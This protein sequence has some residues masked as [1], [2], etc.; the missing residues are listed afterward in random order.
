MRRLFFLIII[1]ILFVPQIALAAVFGFSP[2]SGAYQ[3]NKSATVAVVIN[4]EG[5]SINAFSGKVSV[6]KSVAKI[7]SINDARSVSTFW[8]NRPVADNDGNITFRG[9]I[10]GGFKGSSGV[11]FE[12]NLEILSQG[13][14]S[15]TD[16]E[17]LL[18]D[19]FGTPANTSSNKFSVEI[20]AQ[21]DKAE[22]QVD[23]Q[24][25]VITLEDLTPP[26]LFVAQV[27]Q[28]GLAFDGKWFVIFS[29]ID[30]ESGLAYY[31]VQETKQKEPDKD[32]WERAESPYVLKDQSRKS[33]VFIRAVN[34]SGKEQVV[35]IKPPILN[36][37]YDIYSNKFQAGLLI[38]VVF[39]AGLVYWWRNRRYK[40]GV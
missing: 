24:T 28:D 17:A 8:V 15:I 34:G 13:S 6:P 35:V 9:V 19:G 25:P 27:V 5:Q 3:Q 36:A 7:V 22:N 21:D 26:E 18:N 37:W 10:P 29:T 38:L 32:K 12:L 31:E 1:V 23:G 2:N 14:I 4:T 20:Q 40:N 39:V 16:I 30:R 33:Y 11:L